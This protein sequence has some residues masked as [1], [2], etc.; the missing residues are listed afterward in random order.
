MPYEPIV[1]EGHHL[2]TSHQV[3][4]AVTGHL[5]EDG[6]NDLKGHASWR[7]VD[8]GD[9]DASSTYEPE[10][11]R[12]LTQEELELAAQVATLAAAFIVGVVIE[13]TPYIK[14]WWNGK[15]IPA[16]KGKL[17]NLS[18]SVLAVALLREAVPLQT[19][20]SGRGQGLVI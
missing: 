11:P 20:S 6:T 13:A 10:P 2:G 19:R 7:W 5:F 18:S 4:D 8:E 1:P 17:M 3:D 16:M 15:A 12:P 14:R 9:D